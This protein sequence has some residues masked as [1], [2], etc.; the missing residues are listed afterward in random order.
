MWILFDSMKS[1]KIDLTIRAILSSILNSSIDICR[2]FLQ[3]SRNAS[4]SNEF[5]SHRFSDFPCEKIENMLVNFERN[6]YNDD[7]C[8]GVYARRGKTYACDTDRKIIVRT[9]YIFIS[10][11]RSPFPLLLK[12]I[13]SCLSDETFSV[14]SLLINDLCVC[15]KAYLNPLFAIQR[16]ASYV[17]L[18][19]FRYIS[20]YLVVFTIFTYEVN[21]RNSEDNF[22]ILFEYMR[23]IQYIS[24]FNFHD[25]VSFFFDRRL[26]VSLFPVSQQRKIWE[27][28]FVGCVCMWSS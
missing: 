3:A 27:W 5:H 22:L 7:W 8:G 23:R 12:S 24:E 15:Y 13:R 17:Q 10:L 21:S 25:I 14:C 28:A 26:L 1:W 4:H 9:L 18:F 20:I 16:W 6:F 11:S 2:T 19:Y